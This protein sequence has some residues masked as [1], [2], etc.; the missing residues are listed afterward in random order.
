M[1]EIN[2]EGVIGWDITVVDVRDEL[3]AAKGQ[4]V[5][6]NI[7][8]PG[9]LISEGLK[10]YNA[11]KNY[12]GAVNV[13]LTGMVA[14]M[15]TYIAMVGERRTAEP[16]AIF[17][18]H[19]GRMWAGGDHRIMF[20]AGRHL[21]SLTNMIA[22]EYAAKTD[23]ALPDIRDAMDDET[24]YYG[25]EIEE[26]GFVHEMV[27][28]SDPEDRAEAIATAELMVADC[29]QR[30]NT[31]EIFKKDIQALGTMF[32]DDSGHKKTGSDNKQK[33]S[34]QGSQKPKLE[35]KKMKLEELKRN[36]PEIY[37]QIREEARAEGVEAGV[38]QERARVVSL[39]E[40]RAKFTKP[41]SQKVFDSA[42]AGGEDMATVHMNLMAA[43]QANAELENENNNQPEPP[44]GGGDDD[45]PTMENG[46]MTHQDHVDEQAKKI[47]AMI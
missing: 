17:M 34:Y 28:E 18:I 26:A 37:N 44:E 25:D 47:S 1:P 10:I 41:H 22:K 8:S 33:E 31:P 5:T 14:S 27:G 29:E 9:G 11:L 7:A 23:T 36:H 35:D 21:E 4:D 3:A 13:H 40:M 30:V 24:F 45:V 6:V 42:I 38:Q 20:K 32:A 15:A 43:D 19:N 2:I 39:T 16:N 46:V 12:K